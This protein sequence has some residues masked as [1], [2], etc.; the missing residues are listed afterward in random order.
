MEVRGDTV[1]RGIF[2]VFEG[3][4]GSGTTTQ[5]TLLHESLVKMGRRSV[6]TSEPTNGPVGSVIRQ[7]MTRRLMFSPQ[8]GIVDRFL[9]YLFAADRFDHVYNEVNGILAYVRGGIDVISTRYYLSSFAYH[10]SSEEDIERVRLLNAEFP[11]AD[12][13]VYLECSVDL[14]LERLSRSRQVFERY[15]N[16]AKLKMAKRNYEEVLDSFKGKVVQV[17]GS[18]PREQ[19]HGRILCEVLKLLDQRKDVVD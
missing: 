12:L 6:L 8:L 3:L 15:E 18:L 17:D 4:D 19:Q 2:V 11:I 7:V 13:T 1:V 14:A 5:A 9:A 16:E 10:V